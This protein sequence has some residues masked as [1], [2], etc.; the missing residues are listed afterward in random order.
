MT[1]ERIGSPEEVNPVWPVLARLTMRSAKDSRSFV[2]ELHGTVEGFN[3]CM[4]LRG[5][6]LEGW[7]KGAEVHVDCRSNRGSAAVVRIFPRRTAR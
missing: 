1:L 4:H 7:K 3:N 5:I 6:I 2:A